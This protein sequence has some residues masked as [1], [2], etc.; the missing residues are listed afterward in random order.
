MTWFASLLL[1]RGRGRSPTFK[2]LLLI[3]RSSVCVTCDRWTPA[4]ALQDRPELLAAVAAWCS[5]RVNKNT[6][7]FSSFFLTSFLCVTSGL[8]HKLAVFG[9]MIRDCTEVYGTAFI[10]VCAVIVMNT[11][12]HLS[13]NQ[14]CCRRRVAWR[15]ARKYSP[16]NFTRWRF[17]TLGR[18]RAPSRV[19]SSPHSGRYCEQEFVLHNLPD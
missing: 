18:G 14:V 1:T 15:F 11:L 9:L 10:V 3:K 5:S 7:R 19:R 6:T 16:Y 12:T 4:G 2:L 17:Q 8:R 13:S